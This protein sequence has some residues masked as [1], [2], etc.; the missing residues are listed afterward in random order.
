[1]EMLDK[2]LGVKVMSRKMHPNELRAHNQGMAKGIDI[3]IQKAGEFFKY[4][5]ENCETIDE[6]LNKYNEF[7]AD[8]EIADKEDEA[9]RRKHEVPFRY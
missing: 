2:E 4:V 7:I 3:G 8:A 1:M 6:A 9:R 5:L